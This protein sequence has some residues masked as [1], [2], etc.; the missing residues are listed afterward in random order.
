[1]VNAL[2]TVAAFKINKEDCS[3][4]L[5][6]LLSDNLPDDCPVILKSEF[7]ASEYPGLL[8]HRKDHLD[9]NYHLL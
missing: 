2:S 5:V 1:M 7:I 8:S 3:P 4:Q 6:N 9:I